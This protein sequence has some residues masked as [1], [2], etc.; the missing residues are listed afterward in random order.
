MHDDTSILIRCSADAIHAGPHKTHAVLHRAK[1]RPFGVKRPDRLPV[2]CRHKEEI[3]VVDKSIPDIGLKIGIHTDDRCK[4]YGFS[5][6]KLDGLVW[7]NAFTL[8]H[9]S[10]LNKINQM[11]LVILPYSLAAVINQILDIICQS[12]LAVIFVFH[13]K[14]NENEYIILFRSFRHR[15]DH[16]CFFL[17]R[18]GK[19]FLAKQQNIGS[20]C[21]GCLCGL[22]YRCNTLLK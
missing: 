14:S 22:L 4:L 18:Y 5:V 1:L 20:R 17:I 7:N 3:R 21:S 13:L 9:I 12:F 2:P 16:C 15:L 19:C 6:R 10:C 11:R 8:C